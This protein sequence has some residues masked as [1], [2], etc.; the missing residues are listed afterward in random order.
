MNSASILFSVSLGLTTAPLDG[1]A[2]SPHRSGF[3]LSVGAGIGPQYD[4]NALKLEPDGWGMTAP[5]GLGLRLGV[6]GF[7][8]RSIALKAQASADWNYS[9][10]IVFIGPAVQLWFGDRFYVEP[11]AGLSFVGESAT[12]FSVA[13]ETGFVL[14]SFRHH[15]VAIVGGVN[16]S[17]ADGSRNGFGHDLTARFG[18]AWILH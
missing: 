4:P 8:S 9:V 17:L 1:K 13:A 7:L 2:A 10:P 18:F 5:I 14:L 6:G 11:A 15:S 16:W 3:T 12:R